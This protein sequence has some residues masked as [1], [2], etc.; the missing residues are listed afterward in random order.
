MDL[1]AWLQKNSAN[2][3]TAGVGSASHASGLFLQQRTGATV[4]FV[5]HQ[6]G[7]PALI[8]VLGGHLDLM[9]DQISTSLP[10]VR[11]GGLKS[12][13]VT[14]SKRLAIAPEIPTVDEAGLPGFYISVWSGV[15]APKGTSADV[16]AKLSMAFSRALDDEALIKKLTAL[17][18][19]L[20]GKD[21]RSP[22]ALASLQRSEMAKWT[23]IIKAAVSK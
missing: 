16:I 2:L 11:D 7:G 5:H 6:G 15:W 8:S 4:S 19:E 10:H 23:P 3:G 12:F 17:G 14:T 18:Q 1:V 22:E 9:F 20:P 13:A 21:N